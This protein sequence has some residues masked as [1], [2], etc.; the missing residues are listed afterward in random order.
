MNFLF[1]LTLS[2]LF[3]SLFLPFSCFLFFLFW[4]CGF[5]CFLCFLLCL[6]AVH[7]GNGEKEE[8]PRG[9][10]KREREGA[11]GTTV[12]GRFEG[13]YRYVCLERP[14][15]ENEMTKMPLER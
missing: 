13:V 7:S 14:K 11:R 9:E 8:F 2:I 15:W 4:L 1:E 12:K 5:D 3:Q 6:L 10:G